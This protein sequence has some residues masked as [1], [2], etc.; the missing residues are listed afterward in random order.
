[1]ELICRPL[2]SQSRVA[3]SVAGLT[4]SP[5]EVESEPGR[6]TGQ[7]GG[8]LLKAGGFESESEGKK[9]EKARYRVGKAVGMKEREERE[10]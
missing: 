6:E 5:V 7:R 9:K 2:R 3:L 10:K 4:G 8:E 1:M